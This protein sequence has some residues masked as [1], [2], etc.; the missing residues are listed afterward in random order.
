MKICMPIHGVTHCFDVPEL[1]DKQYFKPVP[2]GNYP[3]FSLALTV[4][5]LVEHI[6]P[7]VRDKEFTKSLNEVCNKYIQA[8][9]EGMPKGVEL[10]ATKV[11]QRA[12]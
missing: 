10:N 11:M 4:I 6:T 7:Q 12:A 5:S 3:E 1:V 8:V 2:P 9:R